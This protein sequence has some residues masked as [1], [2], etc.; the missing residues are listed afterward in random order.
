MYELDIMSYGRSVEIGRVAL[1]NYVQGIVVNL[2]QHHRKEA[3]LRVF[4]ICCDDTA[5]L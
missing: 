4:F 1:V 2:I 3:L 5:Q